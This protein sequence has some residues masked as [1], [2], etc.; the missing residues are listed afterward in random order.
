MPYGVQSHTVRG[1]VTCCTKYRKSLLFSESHDNAIGAYESN[2]I[3]K[4]MQTARS[5]CCINQAVL[6]FK[7]GTISWAM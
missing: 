1:T 2:K 6:L 7:C 5:D 3:N 4:D